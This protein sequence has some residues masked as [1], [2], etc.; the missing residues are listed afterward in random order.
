MS[1]GPHWTNTIIHRQAA[2]RAEAWRGTG[3]TRLRAKTA[4]LIH[5]ALLLPI[6]RVT[7]ARS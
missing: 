3:G 2:G 7:E 1:L 5:I 6:R 4:Q